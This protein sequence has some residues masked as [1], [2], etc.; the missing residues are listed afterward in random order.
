[1][2]RKM[3]AAVVTAPNRM[4]IEVVPWPEPKPGE[5]CVRI[6]GCGVCGSNLAPWEGRPWFKYPFAPGELGHEGWG[7]V[8]AVGDGVSKIREGERVA[9]LSYRAYAEYD[10]APESAVVRLPETLD[11]KAFPGEALG[12]ALNVFRRCDVKRGDTV[13]VVGVGFLGAVLASLCARAGASVIAIS[14]RSFALETARRLGAAHL[15]P[16]RDQQQII[17]QTKEITG[18]N[19]CDRVIEAVGLQ[20]PLDL[21]GELTRERGRL[22]IAG[23]HQDGAR[24]V[25]MQLWNWR[26]LDVVNAH[27]RE[28]GV[29]RQ[30][31]EAAVEAVASGQVELEPLLTHSFAL[32]HLSDAL[33]AMRDRPDK[34]LKAIVRM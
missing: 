23:Y 27:E 19:G 33:N 8:E 4:R 31:V 5:V 10:V 2:T 3:Q 18:G 26:G 13:A 7:R 22:I 9:L 15:L 28:P 24:Q 1:M 25:N 21:A 20:Q 32:D 30:G 14:R 34:F 16:M 29:C 17:H 11:G 6:E 12:C